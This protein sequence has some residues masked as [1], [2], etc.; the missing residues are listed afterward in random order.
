MEQYLDLKI[1][2]IL[3]HNEETTYIKTDKKVVVELNE[4]Y[5][6][7]YKN[8]NVKWLKKN[9]RIGQIIDI[10]DGEQGW[11]INTYPKRKA[12]YQ[13]Q[14]KFLNDESRIGGEL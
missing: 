5:I 3:H 6:G 1:T 7:T 8:D 2:E 9:L 12:Y 10:V 11:A 13:E 14:T 4:T